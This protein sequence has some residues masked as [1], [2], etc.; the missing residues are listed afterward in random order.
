MCGKG[1]LLLGMASA[2]FGN[3][4]CGYSFFVL[5]F[6]FDFFNFFVSCSAFAGFFYSLFSPFYFR[7]FRKIRL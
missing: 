6:G 5:A 2:D 7:D 4:N 3:K 1:S